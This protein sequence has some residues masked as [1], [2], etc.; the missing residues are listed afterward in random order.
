MD[1]TSLLGIFM[2]LLPHSPEATEAYLRAAATEQ[3]VYS[4]AYTIGKSHILLAIKQFASTTTGKGKLVLRKTSTGKRFTGGLIVLNGRVIDILSFVRGKQTTLEIEVDL[5]DRNTYL[6][7]LTGDKGA[8]LSLSFTVEDEEPPPP[9]APTASLTASPTT[10]TLGSTAT[11]SWSTTDAE[12]VTIDNGIGQVGA[13]GS[14]S[15][16]PREPTTYVL[17]AVN[18]TGQASAQVR[19]N[20]RPDVAPQLRR[21]LRR[22]PAP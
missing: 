10:I 17:S 18:I 16:A 8:G 13:T 14:V 22:P 19:V 9:P 6:L 7:A 12:T 2:L 4:E 20:V 1:A 5:R 3:V 15:V 21:G 11:L